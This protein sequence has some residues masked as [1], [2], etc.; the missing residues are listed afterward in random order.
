[1][2]KEIANAVDGIKTVFRGKKTGSPG[3]VNPSPL[4]PKVGKSQKMT[5]TGRS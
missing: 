5:I 4:I 1:M 2:T 3:T